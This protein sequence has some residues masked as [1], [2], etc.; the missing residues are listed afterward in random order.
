[1][2]VLVSLSFAHRSGKVDV[3]LEQI[4][5]QDIMRGI[6]M[7]DFSRGCR[8]SFG[9]G[10]MSDDSLGLRPI[11]AGQSGRLKAGPK[12]EAGRQREL[13][14]ENQR[15]A[16]DSIGTDNGRWLGFLLY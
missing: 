3:K 6:N 9:D 1:M 14:L 11:G 5:R 8:E 4:L 7:L 10:E 16:F 15:F 2:N 13:R 12:A